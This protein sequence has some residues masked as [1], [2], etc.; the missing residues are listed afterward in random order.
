[1]ASYSGL[2]GV[3]SKFENQTEILTRIQGLEEALK[4]EKAL[5]YRM[6]QLLESQTGTKL[7]RVDEH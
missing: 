2:S 6:Q 4:A 1:M 3:S 7:D 5:R